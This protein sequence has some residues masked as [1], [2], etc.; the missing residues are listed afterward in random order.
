MSV[1]SL[2]EQFESLLSPASKVATPDQQQGA[3]AHA[4]WEEMQATLKKWVGRWPV[5]GQ[6][7]TRVVSSPAHVGCIC[8][9]AMISSCPLGP[10]LRG[11]VHL[12]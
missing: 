11:L 10:E 7:W 12:R 1:S 4:A 5:A 6:R 8:T 2:L 9:V 3:V